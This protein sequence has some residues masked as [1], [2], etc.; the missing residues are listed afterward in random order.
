MLKSNTAS[1]NDKRALALGQYAPISLSKMNDVALLD[2][3]DTKYVLPVATLQ[4]I[5]P[6]LANAYYALVVNKQRCSQYQTLYYDSPEFTLYR[7]HHAGILDRY[8]V[9]SREYVDSQLA[10]LEVKH[11]TN[12]GRTIKSRMRTP[13]LATSLSSETAEFLHGAYPYD[14]AELEP[15]LWV[16]YTR[17]TLV[18]R[19]RKERVTIDL[20]L[21]YA[22]NG[23]KVRLPHIAIVEVK[24][25]GFSHHSDME[26]QL[27]AHQVRAVGFSKYCVGISL[28]YP[29]VKHN[30]FKSKLR[31]V[32][33]LGRSHVYI[34]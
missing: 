10:F 13:E 25:N 32:E 6:G 28:L 20:D 22:W 3:T 23:Q 21:G 16:E 5:M 31:L 4:Q 12:K 29:G 17:A 2:R 1:Q 8:K 34:H 15:K 19:H 33:N 26:R 30:N 9:R 14:A 27:H 11:K 18:S 7:R 24:Q